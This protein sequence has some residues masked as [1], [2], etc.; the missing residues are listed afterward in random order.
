MVYMLRG[1][2]ARRVPF[3]NEFIHTSAK[4]I[5][6]IEAAEELDSRFACCPSSEPKH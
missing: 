4:N 2:H 6:Q 5:A 3:T 1:E